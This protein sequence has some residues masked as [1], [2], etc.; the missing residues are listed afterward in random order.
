VTEEGEAMNEKYSMEVWKA[1]YVASRAEL[2]VHERLQSNGFIS[3]VPCQKVMKQ[4]SDRKKLIT[5]PL[6]RGYVFIQNPDQNRLQILETQGVVSFVRNLGT[7][8]IITSQEIETLRLIE[9]LGYET[10]VCEDVF[11]IGQ[12][13]NIKQ[14]VF[15]GHQARVVDIG[16]DGTLYAFL[17]EGINQCVR[18]KVPK[19]I[20]ETAPY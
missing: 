11:N 3:Y 13:V 1:L 18:V 17:L 9:T 15:K 2:K 4:W 14:G 10:S 19:E 16:K 5:Q 20:V 12:K 8:A 7:D 6:L